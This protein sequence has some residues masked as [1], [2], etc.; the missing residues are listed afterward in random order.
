MN[1][2]AIVKAMVT[3]VTS[4]EKKKKTHRK[5]AFMSFSIHLY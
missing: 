2:V 5:N 4:F 3:M 1:L